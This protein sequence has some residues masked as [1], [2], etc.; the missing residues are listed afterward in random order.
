[1]S[2]SAPKLSV[3]VIHHAPEWENEVEDSFLVRVAKAA[4]SAGSSTTPMAELCLLL[5]GDDEI[6]ALNKNWRDKDEATNVLSFP[7][8]AP[9]CS[10]A[11]QTLGDVAMAFETVKREAMERGIPISQHTAH[12][13]VHG[14]LH[15]LGYTHETDSQARKMEALEVRVLETLDLP[16]PYALDAITTGE[17]Q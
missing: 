6:R 3:D 2:E 4:Y 12:L 1:M 10:K 17:G 13:V 11:P 15:L 8:D 5:A 7:F 14:V 9:Q 16:D